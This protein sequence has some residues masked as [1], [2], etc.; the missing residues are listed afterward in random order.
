MTD[1]YKKWLRKEAALIKSDGCTKALD[2]KLDCCYEH[3]LYYHY[4][5]DPRSAYALD[6]SGDPTPWAKAAPMRKITADWRLGKCSYWWRFPATLLF[7]RRRKE[8]ASSPAEG[9]DESN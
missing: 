5:R 8:R 6:L 1:D 3:D 2:I 4:G 7:G 9:T